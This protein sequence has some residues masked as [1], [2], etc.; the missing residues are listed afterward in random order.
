MVKAT[1]R[2]MPALASTACLFAPQMRQDPYPVYRQLRETSPILWDNFLKGWIVTDHADATAGLKDRRF[3]VAR[4]LERRRQSNPNPALSPIFDTLARNLL[5]SDD[6][7]HTRLRRLVHHAFMKAEVDR[8]EETVRQRVDSL[9]DAGLER[10]FQG[11]AWDFVWD[12]AVPLPISVISAIV[13]IPEEDGDKVKAWCDAYSLISV[14]YSIGLSEERLRRGVEAILALKA[15][16]AEKAELYRNAP[17]DNLLSHLVQAEEDGQ[18]LDPDELLACTL[19]LLT[20]GNE[21]TTGLLSNGLLALLR[22]REVMAELRADPSLIPGAVEEFLRYDPPV[23]VSARIATEDLE[24]GGQAIAAGDLVFFILGAAGRDPDAF[25][26]PEKIDPRRARNRH[27]AFGHGAHLCIGM[28]LARMEARIAF[29]RLFERLSTIE[30]TIDQVE[31]GESM[32][33]RCPKHLWLK[34]AASDEGKA[35]ERRAA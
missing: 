15:Y 21:T 27:L 30:L 18:R 31:P 25:E 16:V 26:E 29:E 4:L 14:N 23:Q 33:L 32:N 24:L 13:G 7:D 10:A 20:A 9:I 22:N 34:I 35:V 5:W 1:S 8:Y 11:E 17:A 12:F 6:P 28:H 19:L 3:S 2:Q